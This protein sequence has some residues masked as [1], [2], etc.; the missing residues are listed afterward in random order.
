MHLVT[1][2]NLIAEFQA[3]NR[4]RGPGQQ[5]DGRGSLHRGQIGAHPP[6][7]LPEDDSHVTTLL[8]D[9]VHFGNSLE[10]TNEEISSLIDTWI[11]LRDIEIN[12]ERNRGLYILKSRGMAH[13]N[14]IREVLL[15]DRGIELVDVY[16]GP[17]G[18]LTGSARAAQEAKEK[19]EASDYRARAWTGECA[20]RKAN[21]RPWR[22]RSRPCAPIL[23]W[24]PRNCDYD[25]GR[26][27]KRNNVDQPTSDE[28]ARLRKADQA[29]DSRKEGKRKDV[30]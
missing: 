4:H 14:Q 7:R 21:A 25:G 12:G 15:S 27:E 5:P 17:G 10:Q 8:T 9:L 13:S 20:N 29:T 16:L 30:R 1:I 26:E 3:A 2:H 18:V 19:A 28:M 23:T 22:P 6:F 11:L 24:S